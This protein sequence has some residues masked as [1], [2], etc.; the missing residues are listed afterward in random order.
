L[1]KRG[2]LNFL[3]HLEVVSGTVEEWRYKGGVGRMR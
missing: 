3:Q 2:L 1:L